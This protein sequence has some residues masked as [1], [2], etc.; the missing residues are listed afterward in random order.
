MAA[1]EGSRVSANKARALDIFKHLSSHRA[2]IVSIET[3][4]LQAHVCNATC[5]T[6]IELQVCKWTG[7]GLLGLPR[8]RGL[9]EQW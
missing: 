4:A 1:G 8:Q 7:T 9:S 3:F 6:I 2:S 5:V